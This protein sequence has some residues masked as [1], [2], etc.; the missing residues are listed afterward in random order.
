MKFQAAS[1]ASVAVQAGLCQTWLEPKLLVFS[2][3]GSYGLNRLV[4]HLFMKVVEKT[5]S[6]CTVEHTIDV[7][8]ETLKLI[9]VSQCNR[10]LLEIQFFSTS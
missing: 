9:I 8:V 7:N 5:I 4:T 2:N 3:T 1:C 10:K 6:D